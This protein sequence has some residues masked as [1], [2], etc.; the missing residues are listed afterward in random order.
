MPGEDRRYVKTTSMTLIAALALGASAPA[1]AAAPAARPTAHS[2]THAVKQAAVRKTQPKKKVKC[3]YQ[4]RKGR[5]VR[6]CR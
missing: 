3:T 4:V 1:F 5:K 2:T 6:V